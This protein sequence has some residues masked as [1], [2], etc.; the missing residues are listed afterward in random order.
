M[1][2]PPPPPISILYDDVLGHLLLGG[3]D[4]A[5]QPFIGA[6][7]RWIVALVC[8][9]WHRL[10][11]G[12]APCCASLR[13]DVSAVAVTN[14]SAHRV[15]CA[16]IV[17]AS[18][19]ARLASRLSFDE[20]V[21][22]TRTAYEAKAAH[23][24]MIMVASRNERHAEVVLSWVSGGKG[25]WYDQTTD[26][27]WEHQVSAR[28]TWN[29][30]YER[31]DANAGLHKHRQK[32]YSRCLHAGCHQSRP[33][34]C[35]LLAVATRYAGSES[36]CARLVA[37]MGSSEILCI[38]RAMFYAATRDNLF[39]VRMLLWVCHTPRGHDLLTP[40]HGWLSVMWSVIGSNAAHRVAAY[41]LAIETRTG[42][43]NDVES[44]LELGALFA[45]KSASEIAAWV[46]RNKTYAA[47]AGDVLAHV[48]TIESRQKARRDNWLAGAAI[49]DMP[50]MLDF[51]RMLDLEP[52]DET[53]LIELALKNK[54][55]TFCERLFTLY[56][57]L[58]QS[59]GIACVLERARRGTLSV[60]VAIWALNQSWFRPRDSDDG[61]LLLNWAVQLA[62]RSLADS[63]HILQM[64]V[65]R[66]PVASFGAVDV[67]DEYLYP[68]LVQA[69]VRTDW[70][71]ADRIVDVAYAC[72]LSATKTADCAVAPSG[73]T[74][75]DLWD[76]LVDLCRRNATESVL[77]TDDTKASHAALWF[78]GLVRRCLP[79]RPRAAD[80]ER[81]RGWTRFCRPKPLDPDLL[82]RADTR[83]RNDTSH[84]AVADALTYLEHRGLLPRPRVFLAHAKD[85]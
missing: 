63:V 8:R 43:R 28:E 14:R 22:L 57:H 40:R 32:F 9:R 78:D 11:D 21:S 38:Q 25:I 41:L 55:M 76:T 81:V 45:A 6:K 49:G 46:G 36:T 75:P 77:H 50:E 59:R 42:C 54:S 53:A 79:E 2:S 69:V 27:K 44:N 31:C 3:P 48:S 15:G 16:R 70:P 34:E 47:V 10:L 52:F 18:E 33:T 26:D 60:G 58:T 65:Q 62:K 82:P 24:A 30:L 61:T 23:V 67:H 12:A 37:H 73:P 17:Y 5:S 64:L 68:L 80:A 56:P 1:E 71:N 39:L 7:S 83:S 51:Y 74:T 72:T 35:T 13:G 19:M 29:E 66:W 85:F 84:A 20:A 4:G